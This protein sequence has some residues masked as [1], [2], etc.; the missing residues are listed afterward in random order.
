MPS[1]IELKTATSGQAPK[2]QR[3]HIRV[4]AIMDEASAVFAEKGYD[5][6]TMTEIAARSGTAI[7]SLYRFFPSKEAI[8]DALL[9]RYAEQ[10]LEGLAELQHNAAD[11]TL[12][13]LAGALIDFM[14]ALQSRRSMVLT[15]VD[16]RGAGLD[17]RQRFREALRASVASLLRT[18]LPAIS[19]AKSTVMA[20]ILLHT[21]KAIPAIAEEEPAT[22]SVLLAEF[23]EL[24]RHYLTSAKAPPETSA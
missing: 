1:Q 17:V 20:T 19:E 14:L 15:L 9:S 5:A 21:L 7:G 24:L 2:R 22:R 18:A 10:A 4:A 3:G 13:S 16:A 8:A 6:A 23:R 11:L 12:D